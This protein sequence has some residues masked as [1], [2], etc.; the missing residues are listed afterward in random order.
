M[1]AND[2][3]ESTAI[4]GKFLTCAIALAVAI[5]ILSPVKEPGPIHIAIAS[6]SFMLKSL[7]FIIDSIII[8][9]FCEWVFLVLTVYSH[10]NL[11]SSITHTL[12]ECVDVSI[13]S[14]FII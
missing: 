2:S 14:I 7:S 6:I 8:I 10:I 4:T 13:P 1:N 3:N 9:S 5:D 11:S 12:V